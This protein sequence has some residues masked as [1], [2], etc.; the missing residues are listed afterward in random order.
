[1]A[2]F[3]NRHTKFRNASAVPSI[4]EFWILKGPYRVLH[5]GGQIKKQ[6]PQLTEAGVT[7]AAETLVNLLLSPCFRAKCWSVIVQ[8]TDGLIKSLIAYGEYL[9]ATSVA[10]R[11]SHE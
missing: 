3:F 1:M 7:N 2:S 4:P 6:L 9:K 10:M 11:Y 8:H 5:H